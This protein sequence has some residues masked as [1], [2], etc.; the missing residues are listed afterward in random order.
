MIKLRFLRA[1][2]LVSMLL[3][4]PALA[5]QATIVGPTVGP[6]TMADVMGTLNAAFLAIQGCNSGSSAPANGPGAAPVSFQFWCDTT[7]NPVVVKMYD[8]ASWVVVG[9]LNTSS[10]IWTPEYQ[11]TD[12]GTAS[13]ATTGTSGHTVPF[14]DGTNT[15]STLQTFAALASAAHTITSSSA[16]SLAAGPNGATNP[17]LQIDSSTAS[18]AAGLKITGA[19][20]AGRVDLSVIDSGANSSLGINAKGTGDIQFGGAS[21]GGIGLNRATTISQALT[22]GGVTLANSVTGTGSM[23]LSASPTLTGTLTAS[24]GTFSSTLAS[25]AHTVTSASAQALAAGLNG[26]TNPAFAVDAST[27]SQAAGLKVTGA[28]TGGTVALASIDSGANTNL[29]INAKGTGTIGIGSVSTG[30]VTITPA[31]TLSG[32]LTYGGVTFANTVTGSGSLVGATSP[33]FITPAL[34]TPASGTATNL[35]GLPISTGLTGTGTGVLTALGNNLNASGG[36]VGVSGTLGTPTSGTLSNATGLPLTTGVT[37]TLPISNGG[38]A[39]TTAATARASSGLNVDSFTGHGDSIYTILSTDRTV[40]TNA[41]FTASRTWTL[42]AASAVNPGQEIVVAD[43]QATVTATNTLVISRAG[44]DTINGAA[45]S[46]TISAA[47]G[48]YLLK[49]DGVSKWTA[50]ALGAAAGGGVSSVTCGTGLSGGTITTSGTCAV[51]LTNLTNSLGADVALNNVS[52]YFDGPSVAQGTSGTWKASGTVTL[53][54]TAGA[55]AFICVLT[56]AT[57][58]GAITG[59]KIA[60]GRITSTGASNPTSLGLSG[61][62]TSPVGNIR[63]ACRDSGST[64]GSIAFNNSG[65]SKDSTISVERIQ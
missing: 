42:P 47:S 61:I 53:V 63:M 40:G 16:A 56:D 28:A 36:I 37:G 59:T 9:K 46:V 57:S 64:S 8:G 2:S 49:S 52:N 48:A 14:L 4:S 23:V 19:V 5:S 43:F 17:V 1:L 62:I 30:A 60:S 6:H 39:Q 34:G 38:T 25:T 58:A 13:I 27:A 22:Y 21:T 44:S 18:Q 32:A 7:V 45:T 24:A 11:G 10:H 41:A 51:S 29:S 20:T 50:Q 54:D 12:L 65:N 15:W 26:A 55:A 3:A 33:T 35:T 31:L